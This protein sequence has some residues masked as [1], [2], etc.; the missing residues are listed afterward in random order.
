MTKLKIWTNILINTSQQGTRTCW[1]DQHRC[2]GHR[3]LPTCPFQF[4]SSREN[5]PN[6]VYFQLATTKPSSRAV[7]GVETCRKS[8]HTRASC[9]ELIT[10]SD[11]KPLVNVQQEESLACVSRRGKEM[12]KIKLEHPELHLTG[13]F[14]NGSLARDT[15]HYVGARI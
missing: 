13:D 12:Q 7:C 3:K 11:I 4:L 14:S 6:K 15:Q 9:S 10:E 8:L 2:P 5:K 1:T